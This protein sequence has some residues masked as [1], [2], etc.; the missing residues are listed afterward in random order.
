MR[1]WPPHCGRRA[2]ALGLLRDAHRILSGEGGLE[3]PGEIVEAC[4]RGAADALLKL[5]GAPK[6]PVG[7]QSA[8]KG[9]LA[10]VYVFG[11]SPA[12][13]TALGRRAP[14]GGPDW[15]PVAEAA[16]VLRGEILNPGGRP[17][18]RARGIA[19]RMTGLRLGTAQDNALK[20]W[21]ALYSKAS[22]TL[23]GTGAEE[24]RPAHLYTE[25]LNLTQELLVPLPGRAA[26][27]LELA[28]LTDPGPDLVADNQG[29]L[30]AA[31][32]EVG[33]LLRIVRDDP[34]DEA[35]ELLR[36]MSVVYDRL[37]S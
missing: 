18:R 25:L 16:E 19:E 23:H 21:G 20:A 17:R 13:H 26:R 12:G 15:E 14:A 6:N 32:G 1:S 37:R 29:R 3:R 35:D 27:V 4:V 30:D 28:A 10:A 7:L 22:G 5:P 8:A 31:A 2:R 24:G 33:W 34:Q 11:S 36:W 9:L